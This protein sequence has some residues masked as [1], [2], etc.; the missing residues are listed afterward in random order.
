M[1]NQL[2]SN[3]IRKLFLIYCK[4]IIIVFIK[5]LKLNKL[6]KKRQTNEFKLCFIDCLI[7]F[8]IIIIS[9]HLISWLIIMSL[10][11]T[12]FFTST[13]RSITSQS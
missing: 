3:Q 2:L 4:I 5:K 8:I 9:I 1:Q 11:L 7:K 10:I 6:G 13:E 12:F